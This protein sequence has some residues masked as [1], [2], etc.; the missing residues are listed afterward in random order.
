MGKGISKKHQPKGLV[1]LHEDQDII[2]VNKSSGL[3]T[4]STDREKEKTAHF[5]SSPKT[6]TV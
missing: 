3:L 1:I 2:V 6:S 4:V 5:V